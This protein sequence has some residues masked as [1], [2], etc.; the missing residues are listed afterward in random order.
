[1]RLENLVTGTI[2]ALV[3]AEDAKSQWTAGHSFRVAGL[4]VQIGEKFML[5]RKKVRELHY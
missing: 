3:T 1:M 4:S 2:R 5:P